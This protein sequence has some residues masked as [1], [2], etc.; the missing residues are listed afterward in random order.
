MTSW[1][2]A[3]QLFQAVDPT[4]TAW[5]ADQETA[6]ALWSRIDNNRLLLFYPTGKG[7]T[8]TSLALMADAGYEKVLVIAPPRTH[9]AWRQ[10][11]ITLD[12]KITVVSVEKMRSKDFKFKRGIPIIVDEFH[13]L[14]KHNS[15]GF[16]KLDRN[17]TGFPAIILASATP[18]Y[19]D[20]DRAYCIAH[21]LEPLKNLGGY[22][23]WVYQHCETRTNPFATTP[24]VDG[25]LLHE[26]AADFLVAQ[27]Y[28][29]YIEDDAVWSEDS[30]D[31]PN[32]RDDWFETYGYDR[33][34]H[35]MIASDMEAR[36]RRAYT[37]RVDPASGLLWG[38][39]LVELVL[40]L[41]KSVKPWLVFCR[42][43]TIARAVFRS[44]GLV[45]W[46]SFLITG[47][48]TPGEAERIKQGFL[49][50]EIPARVLVGTSTLATGVDGLD[51]VCDQLLIFNPLEGDPSKERQLIGRVLPRGTSDRPTSVVRVNT[52]E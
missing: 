44:L 13:L 36:H 23:K 42:H 11:A 14:G 1:A 10:D 20:T 28:T 6:H 15:Q 51:K 7:K 41:N 39:V 37:S 17:A 26:D 12:M 24:Y 4:F 46:E 48:T 19:N 45:S 25:F 2:E 47:D 3:A 49:A 35:K 22:L 40:Q 8:K 18:N 38:D 43:S 21:V 9:S 31:L 32:H 29:A 5:T 30:F 34:R 27:G 52:T 16:M 50:S 33:Y